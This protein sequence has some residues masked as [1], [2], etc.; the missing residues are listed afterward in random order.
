MITADELVDGIWGEDPPR[1][2]AGDWVQGC[3]ADGA[4][5]VQL[6]SRVIAVHPRA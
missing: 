1:S 3:E 4:D 2:C 5:E 6:Y